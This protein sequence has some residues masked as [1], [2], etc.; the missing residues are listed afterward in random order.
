MFWVAGVSLGVVGGF[1]A[2][3]LGLAALG[4][5]GY[6]LSPA[7]AAWLPLL[8]FLPWGWAQTYQ[9]MES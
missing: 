5:S 7:L 6:L 8:L 1:S 9:A 3:V 4:T 2:L